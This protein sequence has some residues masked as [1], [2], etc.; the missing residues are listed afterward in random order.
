MG[1]IEEINN[2]IYSIKFEDGDE[3][4]WSAVEMK[5]Y[6]KEAGVAIGD[7]G[8]KFVKY[9]RRCP[10]SGK[11]IDILPNEKRKCKFCDGA[12]HMYTLNQIQAYGKHQG[13]HNRNG[14]DDNN[15]IGRSCGSSS[16]DDDS[17]ANKVNN[18]EDLDNDNDNAN[19]EVQVEKG[20]T[21]SG[22]YVRKLLNIPLSELQ[23]RPSAREAF[24][25]AIGPS[26]AT[27]ADRFK[28]LSIDGRPIVVREYP[29]ET[30]VKLLT[31]A[32]VAYDPEYSR[33]NRSKAQLKKMPF[34]NEFFS[35]DDNFRATPYSLEFRLCDK[36]EC[37]I[38][39]RVGR[40]IRTPLTA[41]GE[42][43]NE[44]LRWL[45]NPIPDVKKDTRHYLSPEDTREYIESKKPSI[46][47]Q[48]KHLP[49]SNK[50]EK[51]SRSVIQAKKEDKNNKTVFAASKL[52]DW[53]SCDSC[54]ARRCIYSMKA[55]GKNGGP[56]KEDKEHLGNWKENGY[57]C[58]NKPGANT[59]VMRRAIRCG[60]LIET[61]YYEPELM[62]GKRK[63][64]RSVSTDAICCLCY[65]DN[66]IVGSSEIKKTQN[67]GGKNPLPICRLCFDSNVKSKV[68]LPTS[69]G[70]SNQ[71]E[72]SGQKRESKK[73]MA[74]KSIAKGYK[75][76]RK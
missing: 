15:S 63:N 69:R 66:D 3:E 60:D 5:T 70:S 11:V 24:D 52:R 29:S 64:G 72:K 19:D 22:K 21:T 2:G 59:F 32:L 76:K 47:D 75:K 37:S 67:I 51:L 34:I 7:I 23:A 18:T 46:E 45:D 74:D 73:R 42:L 68:S 56:C 48:R 1:T 16:D 25:D 61:Q 71:R 43:R 27:V 44:V 38:C 12:I 49:A 65:D 14:D 35:S 9:F 4:E 58:G 26:I 41:N 40:Q 31:D 36:N 53:V 17:T 6:A 13:S 62:T 20:P 33:D 8:Y 50:D 54:R 28:Q 10:F 39:R 57:V 30:E 55:F